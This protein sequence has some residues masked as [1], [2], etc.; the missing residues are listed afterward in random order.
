MK[1]RI[2]QA[3]A[4]VSGARESRIRLSDRLLQWYT[5]NN[6]LTS[7]F[8]NRVNLALNVLPGAS[9]SSKALAFCSSVDSGFLTTAITGLMG[10]RTRVT[11][12]C[13]M[14]SLACL[15]DA[16]SWLRLQNIQ[17]RALRTMAKNCDGDGVEDCGTGFRCCAVKVHPTPAR[18]LPRRS[19]QLLPQP[20]SSGQQEAS[21][22]VMHSN[23]LQQICNS[24]HCV[25]QGA[26][27]GR[28]TIHLRPTRSRGA[29]VAARC[30]KASA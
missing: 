7:K 9:K 24:T 13:R 29:A 28:D 20:A 18:G 6:Y 21:Q 10:C 17:G 26:A 1:S 27:G 23:G 22:S 5:C 2:Q 30:A 16:M 14:S 15:R 4:C 19:M 12:R 11:A 25:T 3:S 8:S